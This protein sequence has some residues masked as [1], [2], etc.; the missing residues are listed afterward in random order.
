IRRGDRLDRRRAPGRLGL[1]SDNRLGKAMPGYRAV[2][3]EMEGSMRRPLRLQRRAHGE[4][5]LGDVARRGWRAPLVRYNAQAIALARQP[6]DGFDEILAVS[7]ED[8]CRAQ[9][10]V[11]GRDS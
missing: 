9:D 10:D 5:S 1:L 8:S 7:P 6:H 4:H 2:S 3:R 11:A